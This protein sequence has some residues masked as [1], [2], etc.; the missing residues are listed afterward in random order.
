MQPD[1]F[2][3]DSH[4]P[5][6]ELLGKART[7]TVSPFFSRN[8]VRAIRLAQTEPAGEPALARAWLHR[9]RRVVVACATACVVVA[10]TS[11]VLLPDQESAYAFGGSDGPDME[12][13]IAAQFQ[14]ILLPLINESDSSPD[15]HRAVSKP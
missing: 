14:P 8:V 5:L 10:A 1:P 15:T 11:M 4:D 7:V 2:K 13:L 12:E 9:W 3:N 6:W